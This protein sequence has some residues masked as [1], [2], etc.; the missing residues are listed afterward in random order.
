MIKKWVW[1]NYPEK[2]IVV[3]LGIA[4]LCK[5]GEAAV[6]RFCQYDTTKKGK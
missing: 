2:T 5:A 1:D 4:A 3:C 6:K